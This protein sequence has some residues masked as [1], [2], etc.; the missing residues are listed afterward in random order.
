MMSITVAVPAG[1]GPAAFR[2]AA[3]DT[4]S[5][6]FGLSCIERDLLLLVAG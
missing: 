1:G 5:E 2:P 3:I 6:L 4:L